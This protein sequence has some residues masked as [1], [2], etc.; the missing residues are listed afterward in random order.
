[1]DVVSEERIY[2]TAMFFLEFNCIILFIFIK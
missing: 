2:T 1:M